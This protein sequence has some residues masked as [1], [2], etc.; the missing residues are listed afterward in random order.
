MQ[1]SWVLPLYPLD[2]FVLLPT[3][4]VEVTPL[5]PT[6]Q[7][8]LA[9]ARR[10]QQLLVASLYED[11]AVHE[12]GVQARVL[13]SPEEEGRAIFQ[14]LQRCRL[15]KLVSEDVPMV[16]A[17][18]YPDAPGDEQQEE[19]LRRLLLRRFA[20]LCARLQRPLPQDLATSSLR[21][22]TW[23]LTATLD[24]ELAQQQGLLNVPDALTRGKIL[25]LALRDAERRERFLRPFSHLRK[26]GQWN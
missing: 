3:L 17:E 9:R 26:G 18:A 10:H 2:G 5:G 1:E 21:E 19:P 23:K 8:V 16:V 7:Q 15:K 14:G 20:R 12:V 25:L 11:E 22:L 4:Q 13:P 24:L 6:A